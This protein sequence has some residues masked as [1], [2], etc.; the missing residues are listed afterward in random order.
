MKRTAKQAMTVSEAKK[1]ILAWFDDNDPW[2]IYNPHYPAKIRRELGIEKATFD[3]AAIELLREGVVQMCEHDHAGLL[4]EAQREE[5]VYGG[6]RP[7]Y[8]TPG[9]M[10]PVY[11]CTL[12][13]R[14]LHSWRR[15]PDGTWAPDQAA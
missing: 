8:Y 14:G 7:S 12:S 1:A 5:L 9:A 10:S 6:E 15:Q 4:T 2:R 13:L 11:Y 3:A